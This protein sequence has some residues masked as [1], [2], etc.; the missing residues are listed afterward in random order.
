MTSTGWPANWATRRTCFTVC[1][2]FTIPG[3]PSIY[4]GS[5]W[6]LDARADQTR[7]L[8]LRPNL[9]LALLRFTHRTRSWP[10]HCAAGRNPALSPAFKITGTIGLYMS[11][12]AIRLRP[13]EW[14][15]TPRVAVNSASAPARLELFSA[16]S[17]PPRR[18][19]CSVRP[20]RSPF[21]MGKLVIDSVPAC[22]AR[23]LKMV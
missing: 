15:G 18:W 12:R 3:V 5:E 14:R 7:R 22:Q 17:M 10:D 13:S 20:K 19:I 4:Y 8:P 23:I 2:L 11:T 1:L 9:D 6:G 16:G 21:Q